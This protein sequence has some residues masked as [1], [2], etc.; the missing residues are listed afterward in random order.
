RDFRGEVCPSHGIRVHLSGST[1]TYTYQRAERNLITAH[2]LFRTRLR[3]NPHKFEKH[4]FGYERSEDCLTWNVFRSMQEARCLRDVLRLITGL[5]VEEEPLLFLWGL[6]MSDDL[7]QPW[8]LL[9]EARRRFES[10][11]PVRRAA[12]EPDAALYVPRRVL[13]L[14]EC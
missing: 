14:I 11:L 7:L 2:Q 1:P 3:H 5:E 10:A 9:L 12:T 8:D 6:S 4:R 13:A